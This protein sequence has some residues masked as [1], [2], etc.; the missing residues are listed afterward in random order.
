M[1]GAMA[2]GA[3]AA[4]IAATL[5]AA[6]GG[7]VRAQPAGPVAQAA[8]PATL[9]PSPWIGIGI[10]NAR[11]Y[12]VLVNTVYPDTPAAD[13]GLLPGDEIVKIAGDPVGTTDSLVDKV[14]SF[15]AGSEVELTVNRG[16][17][18]SQVLVTLAQKPS[19]S[20]LARRQL[21]G[22]P[23]PELRARRVGDR[24]T[25]DLA[26]HR[27]KVVLLVLWNEPCAACGP[28]LRRLDRIARRRAGPDLLVVGVTPGSVVAA[29]AQAQV[30][31]ATMPMA[32][33]LP[34]D[35]RATFAWDLRTPLVI[36]V[37]RAGI[38]RYAGTVDEEI[39]ARTVDTAAALLADQA[40][41]VLDRLLGTR[42]RHAH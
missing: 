36:V 18:A 19:L 4:L 34:G 15:A 22:K 23:V 16:G 12:G 10:Q 38:V 29:R 6:P 25:L 5:L 17:S 2:R 33:E 28:T 26:D 24:R 20:E 31:G 27:G 35:P 39:G 1:L 32:G 41:L 3:L 21:V 14:K 8:T 40:E 37:D 11:P 42:G 30:T 13:A 7:P 9:A